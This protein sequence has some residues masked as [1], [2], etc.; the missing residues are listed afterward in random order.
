[1]KEMPKVK[2]GQVWEDCDKR[3]K[4]RTLRI[5]SISDDGQYA[6]CTVLTG[7]NS[8]SSRNGHVPKTRV[9]IR[10]FRPTATGYRLKS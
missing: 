10:R 1:M 8:K 9:S 2:V 7:T 3:A 4:G 6:Q 5:D